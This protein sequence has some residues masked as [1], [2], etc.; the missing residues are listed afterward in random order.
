MDNCTKEEL[1]DFFVDLSL[2]PNNDEFF[3]EVCMPA[4]KRL[5]KVR[6]AIFQLEVVKRKA[7]GNIPF[8]RGIVLEYIESKTVAHWIAHCK[9]HFE[10]NYIGE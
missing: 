4:F 7:K 3:K 6:P 1:I 5:S 10:E 9:E 8:Y 2:E